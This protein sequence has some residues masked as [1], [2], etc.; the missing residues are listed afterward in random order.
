[1]KL[2]GIRY[3]PYNDSQYQAVRAL[4]G[5]DA[6]A[7]EV[8]LRVL[9]EEPALF[10]TVFIE[11]RLVA[12]AQVNEP[13][14]QSYLT[15]FVCPQMRRQGIGTEVVKYGEDKLRAGGTRIV[16]SSYRADHPSAHAFASR[17]GYEPYFS[18]AYMERTG[19]PYPQE[20][21]PVRRYTDDDYIASQSLHAIA[22]HEM[23]VRVGRF[24]ESAVARSSEQ[25]RS[26][27][28]A[29][30]EDRLV[31]EI[32]GEIVAC[33]HLSGNVLS[34]ISVRPDMQRRGIGRKLTMYACNEI[35]RRGHET[36]S[37]WCV[38][39]NDARCLYDS[40]GFQEKYTTAFIRKTL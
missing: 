28:E 20:E 19:D 34:S 37:L 27:W 32:G 30:A 8:I 12:L 3:E 11:D 23:R 1:M 6:G 15:V 21:L 26:A 38:V 17:L 5:E 31:C 13:A 36:V 16:R 22:F 7:G 39:G 10:M 24:P 4:I 29:E 35:Y 25:E 2:S 9:A 14:A 33:S 40:L 18:S